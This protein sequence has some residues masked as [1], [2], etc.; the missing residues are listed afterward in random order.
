MTT[1]KL[2][3]I[4]LSRGGVPKQ[5]VFEALVTVSGL[6]GDRQRDTRF[7]GGPDRAVVLYSLDVI[8]A[9]QREGHPIAVGATGENL[10]L[11]GVDWA[12][13]VPGAEIVVGGAR[14]EVT[15]YVTPCVKVAWCFLNDD[16]QRIDQ[17]VNPGWS[18]VAARVIGEGL[19]RVGDAALLQAR[20]IRS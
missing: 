4:N 20:A 17:R 15:K 14:L 6:D 11:A 9:L 5:S 12:H 16:Y 2:D 1:G 19:V 3:A 8:Q 7:H 13:V 10:T 18:R